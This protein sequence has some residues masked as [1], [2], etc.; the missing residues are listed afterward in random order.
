MS[1]FENK[2]SFIEK[3]LHDVAFKT[4]PS[5]IAMSDLESRLN[6]KKL[7][8]IRIEQPTFITALPR[9]GT[10]LLLELAVETR[11]FVS[12]TYRDMPFLLTPMFWNSFSKIFKQSD[13][14]RE[15]AHGDGMLVSVDS[16]EAFEEI[17]WKAFWPSRY[18]KDKIVPWAEPSYPEFEAFL[19]DHI[20]KLIAL[21][22][23]GDKDR[24][25]ISK[26]NLNISRLKYISKI[27]LDA[28]IIVPF[29]D[30]IQH[31]SSL[32]RQHLNFINIHKE[33]AFAKKYMAAI[34][35][36]DFGENLKPVDFDNWLDSSAI[37][38]P[39]KI[40]FWLQY[41]SDSYNYMMNNSNNNIQFIAYD[42]MCENPS[43]HMKTFAEMLKLKNPDVLLQQA[44]RIAPPKPYQ[45]ELES[46]DAT[47][48]DKIN[49]THSRLKEISKF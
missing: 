14:P 37:K 44:E 9:A 25:Y 21:R 18:R 11:E 13:T 16:P 45:V 33:D 30:P 34:G 29:R 38:D 4:F 35:H 17:I 7:Q 27:F 43:K 15:R 36:F 19:R 20:V 28:I 32:L 3:M 6:K 46:I 8:D 5:Q 2:Y 49:S 31:A 48:L 47:I 12:H 22:G 10:T 23:E 24:R 41:W 39:Q 40:D 42:A 1:D 26:N